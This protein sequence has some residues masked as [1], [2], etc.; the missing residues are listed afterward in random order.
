MELR[1]LDNEQLAINKEIYSF[2]DCQIELEDGKIIYL[3]GIID[4]N[5]HKEDTSFNHAH[6]VQT[7]ASHEVNEV[8]I[9]VIVIHDSES[10]KINL[11]KEELEE[12]K[13]LIECDI[14]SQAIETNI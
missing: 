14:R 4:A 12:C 13:A 3:S 6:G 1:Y 11:N 2:G 10:L 5:F 8:Y 7:E 9:N